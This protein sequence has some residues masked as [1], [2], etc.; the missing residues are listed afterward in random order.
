MDEG[1]LRSYLDTI[2]ERRRFILLAVGLC[3]LAAAL[4]VAIASKQYTANADMLI[5]PVPN[6]E[7]SVLGLGLLRQATDPSG[8]LSTAAQLIDSPQVAAR[9]G[10]NLKLKDSPQALLQQI[11]VAPLANSSLVEITASTS[12]PQR[13]QKLA[14]AFASA[15]VQVR[16]DELYKALD[17]AITNLRKRITAVVGPKQTAATSTTAQPLYQ[18][19][20]ALES[21][22]SAPDPTIQFATP[23]TRPTSASSPQAKLAIVG[24]IIAGLLIGIGGAFVLNAVDPRRVRED[25]LE[26]TGLSVLTRVPVLGRSGRMRHAFDEAFRSLRT[27]LRFATAENPIA[28]LAVTSPSEREG[29]TTTA[30]QLAMATLEAGQSV[31]LVEA[32][33]FRP[34]LRTL[35]EYRDEVTGSGLLEYLAGTASLDEIIE[36]TSL[37]GLRFVSSGSGQPTSITAL[38][39]GERGRSFVDDVSG[40]AD[41][42]I[43]DCPP[44]GP[45]S[46]AILIASAADAVL[47]VVDLQRSDERSVTETVRRL[48]RSGASLLGIVLNRDDSTTETYE[49]RAPEERPGRFN[50]R[51][52]ARGPS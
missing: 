39:E 50:R 10:A 17:P 13:S 11:S 15:A 25:G 51:T 18:Q 29:K 23:A 16:T 34:G 27:T 14:N 40:L 22:R 9:A 6:T 45:R 33:P 5:T 28:T 44:V 7:T 36:Q 43:L 24:G 35:L 41:V 30:F 21:L 49:Y 3:T 20:A 1:P 38:L 32:D 4:Y 47:L 8:D 42:V 46:D 37:P 12:S 19:L 48:R 52:L 2:R 31:L 26:L